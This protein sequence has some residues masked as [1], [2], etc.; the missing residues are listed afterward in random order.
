MPV[1]PD[2]VQEHEAAH[3]RV[4]APEEKDRT[5]APNRKHA[6]LAYL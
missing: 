1:Q 4:L 6:E 2:P 5:Q 3:L